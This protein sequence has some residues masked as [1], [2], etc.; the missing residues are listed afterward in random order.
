MGYTWFIYKY[1]VKFKK[2][3]ITVSGNETL[4]VSREEELI[5]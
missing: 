4:K 3:K 1:E 2:K 5:I